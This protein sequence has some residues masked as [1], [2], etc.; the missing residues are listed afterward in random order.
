VVD[1]PIAP[2]SKE[3]KLL[4]VYLS[5][6][7][8]YYFYYELHMRRVPVESRPDLM[9]KDSPETL[10]MVRQLGGYIE[11]D[12]LLYEVTPLFEPVLEVI[13]REIETRYGYIRMLPDV[14]LRPVPGIE[15]N[16]Y[17]DDWDEIPPRLHDALFTPQRW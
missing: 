3:E 7:V 17:N 12:P 4:L 1:A 5:Y 14:A 8:P 11:R 16:G 13:E 2:G 6:L 15:I 10:D 9:A